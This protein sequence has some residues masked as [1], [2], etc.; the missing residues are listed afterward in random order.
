MRV[1]AFAHPWQDI[2]TLNS[3]TCLQGD[4]VKPSQNVSML[5]WHVHIANGCVL[6]TYLFPA[7]CFVCFSWRM[8]IQQVL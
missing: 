1:H 6:T 5:L 4:V 2:S 8:T 7:H 3:V